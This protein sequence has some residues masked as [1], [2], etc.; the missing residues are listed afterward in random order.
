MCKTFAQTFTHRQWR[1]QTIQGTNLLRESNWGFSVLLKDTSTLTLGETGIELATLRLPSGHSTPDPPLPGPQW[2][3]LTDF[4][5]FITS[6]KSNQNQNPSGQKWH[7]HVPPGLHSPSSVQ[8]A[9][10]T[11]SDDGKQ[12][13][14][15]TVIMQDRTQI[16]ITT[17][18]GDYGTVQ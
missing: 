2:K 14:A 6:N 3:P 16:Y 1:K 17:S 5:T 15:V 18:P 9:A 4:M 13:N 12:L 11:G 7:A 8:Q 10:T